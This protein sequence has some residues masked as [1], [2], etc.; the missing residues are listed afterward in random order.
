[1]LKKS[2]YDTCGGDCDVCINFSRKNLESVPVLTRKKVHTK[3][4]PPD[5]S[6]IKML[7]EHENKTVDVENMSDEEL[8]QLEISL[9]GK[10]SEKGN[11]N[12]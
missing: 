4:V 12:A 6:A 8:K 5:M 10:L 2:C 3:Y 1:M 7:V 9:L 11:E